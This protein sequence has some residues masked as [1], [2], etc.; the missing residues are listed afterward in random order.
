[1]PTAAL[2]IVY[3]ALVAPEMAVPLN[4]HWYVGAGV[5]LAPAVK[6]TE[7][8][9]NTVWLAGCVVITGAAVTVKTAVSDVV[10]PAEFE[11]IA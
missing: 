6:V 4:C 7:A 10:L 5:P 1:L 8:P 9:V 11:T 2:A 3:E